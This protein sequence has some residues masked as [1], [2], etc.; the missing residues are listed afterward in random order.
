MI[1]Y[2]DYIPKGTHLF[3]ETPGLDDLIVEY[4]QPH[5]PLLVDGKPTQYQSA[6]VFARAHRD[7]ISTAA[8]AVWMALE[9]TD[10]ATDWSADGEAWENTGYETRTSP[11]ATS[12]PENDEIGESAED[13][14][15]A[16]G[17]TPDGHRTHPVCSFEEIDTFNPGGA[18]L[19]LQCN[20]DPSEAR[21]AVRDLEHYGRRAKKDALAI[22]E[23]LDAAIKAAREGD[24]KSMADEL[25]QAERAEMEYGDEPSTRA[26][27]Q[28]L[29]GEG[30]VVHFGVLRYDPNA[31]DLR[32]YES[33]SARALHKAG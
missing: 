13:W 16:L 25:Y 12:I 26:A 7:K 9:L 5:E 29:L 6:D 2:S 21:K 8:A 19:R 18:E 24:A 17:Y 20:E 30:W 11:I 33:T 23:H 22:R 28:A 27:R 1:D 14:W 32:R 3:V 15:D 4:G 31:A 10:P